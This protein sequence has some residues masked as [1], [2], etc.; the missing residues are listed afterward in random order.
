VQ[1]V[2]AA[3]GPEV[4]VDTGSVLGGAVLESTGEVAGADV[5]GWVGDGGM[6]VTVVG[7][8]GPALGSVFRTARGWPDDV[9]PASSPT[10]TAAAAASTG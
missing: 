3:G 6:D 5:S 8:D 1:V 4:A 7:V 10:T 2:C 9:Q